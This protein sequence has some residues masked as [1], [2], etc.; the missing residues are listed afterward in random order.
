MEY[1]ICQEE[2]GSIQQHLMILIQ[3]QVIMKAN[4]EVHL[5]LQQIQ[6]QNMQQNIV[7]TQLHIME[8]K[9]MK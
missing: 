6:V 4:M 7:I 8:Q 5:H 3:I 9:Y 2:L 1:M